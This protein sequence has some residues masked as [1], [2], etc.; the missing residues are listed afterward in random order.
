MVVVPVGA[1]LLALQVIVTFAL[2]FAGG[3]T[4]LAEAVADTPLGNSFTLKS[5]AEW[6]PFTLV[7]V[8]VV[9]TLPRSSTVN[10]DGDRDRVKF[11]VPVEALTVSAM[12][13]L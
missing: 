12:V 7:T 13:V 9:V 11:A 5:T 3:V 8:R 4:G 6:N 2:P 1:F 10:D